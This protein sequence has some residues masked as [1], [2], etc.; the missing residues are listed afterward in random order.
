MALSG[1]AERICAPALSQRRFDGI[2]WGTKPVLMKGGERLKGTQKARAAALFAALALLFSSCSVFSGTDEE[3]PLAPGV[4]ESTVIKTAVASGTKTEANSSATLDYSNSAEGYVMLKYSS[5]GT[6]IKTQITGPSG[7]AYTYNQSLSGV[8]DVYPLSDGNGS[9]KISVYENISGRSYATVFAY[10]IT[11]SL[12]DEFVPFLIPNK[13][14][15]YSASSKAVKK[16][17]E[18][19]AG[20]TAVIKKVKAVYD[21]VIT[22][23]SYDYQL[24]KTVQSGYIPELDTVM[25]KKKGICFDYAAV[26]TAMLRSQGIPT[27]LVFGYAGSVYHAWIS[28]YSSETGWINSA[29]YFDGKHWKLMDP[30]FASTGMSSASIM[31]YI[32]NGKNYSVKYIY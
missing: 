11:V 13:Y 3:V 28:V 5:S 7:L 25:A 18:L 21:Y 6:K 1:K 17:A 16:S 19:C 27:K 20:K 24:A 14:V 32:G 29:I 31:K 30:T 15:N 12:K 26:M 22:N 8:W 10:A 9:Y 4:T 2:E 23:F